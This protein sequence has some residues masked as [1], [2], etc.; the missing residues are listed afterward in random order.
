MAAQKMTCGKAAKLAANNF[1]R[2]GWVFLGWATT[3]T[4]AVAYA[5]GATVKNLAA[6]G[7]TVTLYARW[8]VAKY[9]VAFYGTYTGAKGTMAVQT[10]KYGT[11]ANLYANKFTRKGYVFAGWATSAA[12]AKAGKVKYKNKQAVKN[13]LPNGKTVKLYA[14]WKKK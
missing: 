7:G 14:V 5:N 13:L 3:K 6:A 1:A 4:G 12:N 2:K 11:A 10:F 8:A 9:K